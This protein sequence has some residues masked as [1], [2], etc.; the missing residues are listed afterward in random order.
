MESVKNV[1]K[2]KIEGL[3]HDCKKVMDIVNQEI[4]NGVQLV[5]DNNGEKV[6]I[7][8]CNDCYAQNKSLANFQ[9]CEVYSRV[10]GYIRPVS[11]WHKGKKQEY[12]ERKEYN[13]EC[14]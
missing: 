7:F 5:Y 2:N 9:Q 13:C 12:G 3:C 1:D 4:K 8:K 6:K 14:S 10:V 11:Q